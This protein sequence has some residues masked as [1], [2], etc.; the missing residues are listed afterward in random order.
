MIE[1]NL[2]EFDIQQ[3]PTKGHAL[4]PYIYKLV[5]DCGYD[6]VKAKERKREV[7]QAQKTVFGV[8]KRIRELAEIYHDSKTW[9]KKEVIEEL[10]EVLRKAM[11]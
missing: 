8:M 4:D 6:E 11:K 5:N 3:T 10:H 9:T 7:E 1:E 2:I